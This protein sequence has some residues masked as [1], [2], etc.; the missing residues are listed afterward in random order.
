MGGT[1]S[2]C[3]ALVVRGKN[4]RFRDDDF[5][6]VLKLLETAVGDDI[7]SIQSLYLGYPAFTHPWRDVMRMGHV[8]FDQEYIGDIPIVLN[9]RG[10]NQ[11]NVLERVQKQT[12]I[13][14]L[15]RKE[16]VRFVLEQ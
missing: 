2:R 3:I 15:V 12:G 7:S 9:G 16:R 13:H 5:G 1:G 6:T 10:R 11:N 8:V 14:E 4:F